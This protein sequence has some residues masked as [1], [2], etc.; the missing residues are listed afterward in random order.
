MELDIKITVTDEAAKAMARGLGFTTV[1]EHY[2][3]EEF[4]PDTTEREPTTEE[5]EHFL[6]GAMLKAVKDK[7][8]A[9]RAQGIEQQVL[10]T[11]EVLKEQSAKS[12]DDILVTS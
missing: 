12:I 8:Q 1:V 7:V 10:K 5:I 4:G 6:E 2:E 11:L 3:D 9:I